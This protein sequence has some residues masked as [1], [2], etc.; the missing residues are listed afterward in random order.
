VSLPKE[1]IGEP[2]A[3]SVRTSAANPISSLNSAIIELIHENNQ[4]KLR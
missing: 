2:K 4:T 1:M 3:E